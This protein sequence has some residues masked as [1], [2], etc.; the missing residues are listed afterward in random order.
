MTIERIE[1]HILEKA[2]AEADRMLREARDAAQARI[3]EARERH[4]RQLQG[5]V[6][7]LKED[8]ARHHQQELAKLRT[9]ERAELLRIK[10]D[11]IDRVFDAAGTR[12]AQ[13]DRYL[14]WL[15]RKLEAARGVSGSLL[16]RAEDTELVARLLKETGRQ[17][18]SVSH[19]TVRIRGGW[20]L[21]TDKYDLDL[22]L[23]AELASL[24]EVVLPELARRIESGEST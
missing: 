3:G 7:A 24:R 23:D 15:R 14:H 17:D 10:T 11:I 6:A 1:R 4:A 2:R 21:R 8:L 9:E 19:E 12:L 5:Q 13:D 20:F 16:C 18:L 22:T